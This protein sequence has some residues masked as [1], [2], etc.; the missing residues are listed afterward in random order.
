MSLRLRRLALRCELL[1]HYSN[2]EGLSANCQA[3]NSSDPR[4]ALTIF[5]VKEIAHGL[6]AGFIDFA[7]GL[8]LVGVHGAF[9]GGGG[10]F[11]ATAFGTAVSEARFIWL[12]LEFLPTDGADFDRKGHEGSMIRRTWGSEEVDGMS[13]VAGLLFAC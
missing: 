12:Q 5:A 8:A 11:R 4:L 7:D 9:G 13:F 2:V 3:L 10:C 1:N 6:L